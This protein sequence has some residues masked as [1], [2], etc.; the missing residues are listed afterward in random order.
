M[1]VLGNYLAKSRANVLA[2]IRTPWTL[3]SDH[4]WV[5]ANRI[6]GWGF[7]ATGTATALSALISSPAVPTL[8]LLVG[9]AV[10]TIASVIVSYRAWRNDPD[11]RTS[12][13]S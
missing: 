7:V 12:N 13:R 2:G 4:A 10:S 8:V 11:S 9:L 3:A 5:T 1:T 6:A